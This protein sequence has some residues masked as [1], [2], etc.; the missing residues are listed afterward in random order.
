MV[1][2][3]GCDLTMFGTGSCGLKMAAAVCVVH[4]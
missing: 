1:T 3:Q 4:V 2:G